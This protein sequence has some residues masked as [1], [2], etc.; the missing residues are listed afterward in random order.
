[1]CVCGVCA[2]V[3]ACTYMCVCIVHV[4]VHV[5]VCVWCVFH[6]CNVTDTRTCTTYLCALPRR[7]SWICLCKECTTGNQR[8]PQAGIIN[9]FI[10]YLCVCMCVCV[11]VCMCV[12]MCVCVSVC[13]CVC[14]CMCVF[15]A[16][17][18]LNTGTRN[19]SLGTWQHLSWRPNSPAKCNSGIHGGTMLD[20]SLVLNGCQP[21]CLLHGTWSVPLDY[22]QPT[23]CVYVCM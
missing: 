11:C 6:E 7:K 2:Y 19:M 22:A 20:V 15:H 4:C 13:V 21:H 17:N 3:C 8:V 10:V 16:C 12:C 14:M 9:I 1:M 5:C 23:L 18:V